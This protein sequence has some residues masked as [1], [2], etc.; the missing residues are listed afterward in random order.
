MKLL[1]S[2][3]EFQIWEY[4]SGGRVHQ[5][6]KY[7]FIDVDGVDRGFLSKQSIKSRPTL[8]KGFDRLCIVCQKRF[9]SLAP[10]K[11]ICSLTCQKQN[12]LLERCDFCQ[13]LIKGSKTGKCRKCFLQ[14]Q[15]RYR[16][17]GV[18]VLNPD[19][20]KATNAIRALLCA[21]IKFKG[22][23]KIAK[24][25]TLLGCSIDCF[26]LHLESKFRGNMTWENHGS[27]WS[28]DHICPCSQALNEEEL[29]KLQHYT[30][31]QPLLKIENIQKS[32]SVT[33]ES[34]RLCKILLRRDWI[35]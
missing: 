2:T 6:K 1:T 20:F 15:G 31:L 28:F 19:L 18:K 4:E 29:L 23:K 26:K 12:C 22:F 34:E 30:N 17:P 10:N 21:S 27:V 35:Y 5:L 24:T 13:I 8:F 9:V 3:P 11:V 7:H 25:T 14:L 33:I 32:D 16:S